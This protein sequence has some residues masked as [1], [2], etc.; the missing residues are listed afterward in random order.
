MGKMDVSWHK[1]WRGHPLKGEIVQISPRIQRGHKKGNSKNIHI[2]IHN[3]EGN[4]MRY[5]KAYYSAREHVCIS[6]RSPSS[7]LVKVMPQTEYSMHY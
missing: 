4:K 2:Y 3:V 6:Q 5:R 1:K 7:I